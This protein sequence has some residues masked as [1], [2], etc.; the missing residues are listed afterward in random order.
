MSVLSV[1]YLI[2]AVLVAIYGA[3]TLLLAGL[4]LRHRAD[5]PSEP[6]EPETWP[7]VTVQLPVYNELYVVKRLIDKRM[8]RVTSCVRRVRSDQS[9]EEAVSL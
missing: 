2:A 1:I 7:V 6:P 9:Q 3:N 5:R 8:G 4:Y